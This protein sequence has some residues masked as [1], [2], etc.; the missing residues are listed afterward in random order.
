MRRRRSHLQR[1]IEDQHYQAH[2]DADSIDALECS[3]LEQDPVTQQRIGTPC[4]PYLAYPHLGG[5]AVGPKAFNEAGSMHS[6]VVVDAPADGP[7]GEDTDHE[8]LD[9]EGAEVCTRAAGRRLNYELTRTATAHVAPHLSHAQSRA[10]SCHAHKITTSVDDLA[11]LPPFVSVPSRPLYI[12]Y[13]GLG[14]FAHLFTAIPVSFFA[15]WEEQD[16]L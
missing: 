5:P 16:R 4:N 3:E 12:D 6:Y 13:R 1:W 7:G 2:L 9:A 8:D 11:Q 10:G 15:A 14:D